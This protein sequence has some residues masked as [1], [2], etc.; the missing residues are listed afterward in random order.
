VVAK[1]QLQVK[2]ELDGSFKRE[3]TERTERFY[4]PEFFVCAGYSSSFFT[5][6]LF[7]LFLL[8]N[9]INLH[10][11]I[12]LPR[13]QTEKTWL[14]LDFYLHRMLQLLTSIF[15]LEKFKKMKLNDT[16]L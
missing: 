12:D 8:Q 15:S 7:P 11:T 16:P 2:G 3:E 4:A 1:L 6:N 9:N 13:D 10:N 14:W 5:V